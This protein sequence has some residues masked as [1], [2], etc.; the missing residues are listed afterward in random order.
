VRADMDAA[1][2]PH[3]FADLAIKN[4]DDLIFGVAT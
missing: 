1:F 3:V 4:A 2:T